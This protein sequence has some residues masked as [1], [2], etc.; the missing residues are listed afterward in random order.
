MRLFRLLDTHGYIIRCIF[1]HVCRKWNKNNIYNRMNT[2]DFIY[3]IPFKENLTPLDRARENGCR[4]SIS[5]LEQAIMG[6]LD[7][8]SEDDGGDGDN[9]LVYRRYPGAPQIKLV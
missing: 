6:L 2:C 1:L 5:L 8:S 7:N 3:V 4:V 9:Q